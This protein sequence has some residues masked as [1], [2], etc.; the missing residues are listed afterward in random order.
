M[1]RLSAFVCVQNQD[2][3]LAECL[4]KLSFC[5]EIVVVADRCTDRSREIARRAGAR[6][7]DGIFPLESQRKAAGAEA[8]T[9]DWVLPGR[10]RPRTSS[11]PTGR[12]SV[13]PVVS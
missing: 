3:Q 4:R 7:I 12:P 1:I 11:W 9:G 5:D 2:V 13:T 6:I 8:C 10:P